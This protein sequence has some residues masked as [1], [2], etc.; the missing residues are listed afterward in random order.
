VAFRGSWNRQPPTGYKVVRVS[1]DK[2]GEPT[3]YEDFLTGFL[4]D[5][6]GEQPKHFGRL[7]GL[8]VLPDGSLLVSDDA[9]GVIYRVSHGEE[10]REART[11]Q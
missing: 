9:N 8:A 3:G 1:F 11:A 6:E 4:L 2:D 10:P 7:A 5:A